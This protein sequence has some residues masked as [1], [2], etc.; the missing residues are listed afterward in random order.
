MCIINKHIF[1]NYLLD[2]AKISDWK[3]NENVFTD[4][5]YER[6][7]EQTVRAKLLDSLPNG[8]AY[9]I[10]V[11]IE[12]FDLAEDGSI[13]VLVALKCPQSHYMSILLRNGGQCIKFTSLAVEDELQQAFRTTVKV[14]LC[15]ERQIKKE[16]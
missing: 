11:Q 16:T 7:I 4:Q 1:Q 15:V 10:Q 3:Y 14:K 5:P 12:H 8:G 13:N 2:S 9:K 6:I